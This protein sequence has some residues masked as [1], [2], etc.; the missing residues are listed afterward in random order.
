MLTTV[1][2]V[3]FLLLVANASPLLAGASA[4]PCGRP[5]GKGGDA[6]SYYRIGLECEKLGKHEWIEWRAVP[7][8]VHAFEGHRS[9]TCGYLPNRIAA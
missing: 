6:R 3:L 8:S 1:T 5:G 4:K 9:G 2:R 7:A